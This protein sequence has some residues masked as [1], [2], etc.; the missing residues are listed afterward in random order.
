M[1]LKLELSLQIKRRKNPVSAPCTPPCRPTHPPSNCL[2]CRQHNHSINISCNS[3]TTFIS[4]SH[5]TKVSTTS[6]SQSVLERPGPIDGTPGTPRSGEYLK[7][8]HS[9]NVVKNVV[10]RG[11]TLESSKN[12][13]WTPKRIN[14][15]SEKAVCS[16]RMF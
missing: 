1:S 4:Q 10:D 15:M 11:L 13:H 12:A 14:S 3:C 2:Y 6:L 9:K 8:I 5:I 7:S 16:V